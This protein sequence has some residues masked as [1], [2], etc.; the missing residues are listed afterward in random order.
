[1]AHEATRVLVVGGGAAGVITTAALLRAADAARPV[2]VTLVERDAVVGPGLAYGTT[3][4]IHLLNNYA[5]RMSAL[6]HDPD[7]LVR[8]CRGQGLDVD[9]ASFVPRATYGDYLVHLLDGVE[10]PAGSSV[11]RVR[12][13]VVDVTDA[14]TEYLAST[15]AGA[16]LT[17]D[18]VVLAL[19]NPRPRP[20]RDLDVPAGRLVA[21]P[22][23]PA[24]LDRVADGD[25]VLLVGTGLTTVD[26]A[27]Q[28]GAHRPAARMTAVSRHGLLP[29]RHVP[30]PPGPAGSF[31]AEVEGLGRV[32]GEA[33]RCLD[34][35]ADW[36]R[37][38]ESVKAAGNDL[39]RALGP[40]DRDRFVRH[41]AR[42]WEIARHRMAPAMA[43]LVDDLL[44]SGRL[45][46][47]RAGSVAPADFDVVVCCTG[48]APVSSTGWSPLVDSLALQGMLWPSSLGL[49]VDVDPDGALLDADGRRGRAIFAVGAARRGAEWEVAAVPDLRR[50]A[51]RLA[52]VL[53]TSYDEP[54]ATLIG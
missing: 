26:V 6:E 40:D 53:R 51:V 32:L 38:V 2:A 36:R 35:G 30:E 41:V 27:A 52:D 17:A 29:L 24:L 7:H 5:S 23:D 9:G 19:G 3:E 15:R 11:T 44:A 4:P 21:D 31:D 28:L 22:W 10:V 34:D 14:G 47:A 49:G 39:W 45:T 46:I 16:V 54:P 12:D 13:E 50:Q 25:R 20:P 8:W 43:D 48:P 1:M 33:R 37:V 42:Y 18:A